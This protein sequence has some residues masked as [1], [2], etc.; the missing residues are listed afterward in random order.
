LSQAVVRA[1]I[2]EQMSADFE[3]ENDR[4]RS[5]FEDLETNKP[6]DSE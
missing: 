3:D 6:A 2:A 1:V 4:L 5:D